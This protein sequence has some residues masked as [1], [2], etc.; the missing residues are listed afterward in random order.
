MY[1]RFVDDVVFVHSR[2]RKRDANTLI[3]KVT[4]Q[5][6]ESGAKFLEVGLMGFRKVLNSRSELLSHLYN[7]FTFCLVKVKAKFHYAI[8][9]ADLVADLAFD[10]FVRVCNQLATFLSRKQVADRFELS[11]HV[12]IA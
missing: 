7:A 2:R 8:Q 1:F 6:T 4:Y 12:E 9:V 3:R 11:R 5:G 10:K